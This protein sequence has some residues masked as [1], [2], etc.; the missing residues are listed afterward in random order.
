MHPFSSLAPGSRSPGIVD[1]L[2]NLQKPGNQSGTTVARGVLERMVEDTGD[3]K[4]DMGK[5]GALV[6]GK[7]LEVNT[8]GT[9]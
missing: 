9:R 4:G 3:V 6:G 5:G 2:E 1:K 7:G 8:E